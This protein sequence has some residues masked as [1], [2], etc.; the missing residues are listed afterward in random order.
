[1]KNCIHMVIDDIVSISDRSGISINDIFLY[2]V[3]CKKMTKK[4]F[5]KII[6]IVDFELNFN[7]FEYRNIDCGYGK[8]SDLC[9]N[10]VNWFATRYANSDYRLFHIANEQ[11]RFGNSSASNLQ[12][13]L[14]GKKMKAMGKVGGVFDYMLLGAGGI[15]FIEVKIKGNK[16]SDM[17]IDYALYLHRIGID[18]SV[19]Y[20]IDHLETDLINW[21]VN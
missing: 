13:M 12:N 20:S 11:V 18:Y 8:E 15:K 16:L 10:M 19:V 9:K 2:C 7:D 17:Q 4:D 1:M 21:G 14:A 3:G 5:N 6:D